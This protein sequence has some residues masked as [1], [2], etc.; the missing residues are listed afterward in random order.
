[1]GNYFNVSSLPN[2]QQ[3]QQNVANMPYSM[4][5]SSN[6][7]P[8][9]PFGSHI[10]SGTTVLNPVDPSGVL[11]QAAQVMNQDP[12]ANMG[13]SL[14]NQQSYGIPFPQSQPYNN[15]TQPTNQMPFGMPQ[16][17]NNMGGG[18]NIAN[19]F[20][21]ILAMIFSFIGGGANLNNMNN[22]GNNQQYNCNN[23]SHSNN[24]NNNA[25]NN[26]PF[27]YILRLSYKERTTI[28]QN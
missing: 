8:M 6:P 28:T 18:N 24:N 5:Q 25:N 4:P 26:S 17:N 1:M 7:L 12:F 10:L 27:M 21:S 14:N 19:L 2:F 20:K 11:W 22:N 23:P 9:I 3:Q 13:L 15:F 16:G